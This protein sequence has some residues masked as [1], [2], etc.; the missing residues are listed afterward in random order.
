M[1]ITSPPYINTNPVDS[2]YHKQFSS[3][4]SVYW[5]HPGLKVT[6][7]RL[8]GD[9]GFPF[10]DV[11]YCYGVLED[12]ENVKVLLPF[13]QLPV[14]AYKYWIVC[15]AKKEKI[16]AADLGIISDSNISILV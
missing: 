12:G 3:I 11:S 5:N 9:K 7:L 1:L 8:L 13:Q 10:Y 15:H 2:Q 4:R 16:F 6:R 14:K